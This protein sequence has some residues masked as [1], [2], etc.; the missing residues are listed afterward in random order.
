MQSVIGDSFKGKNGEVQFA[1]IDAQIVCLLF[2][3][4][5]CPPCRTFLTVLSDFY[6]SVNSPKKRLEIIHITSDKDEAGFNEHFEQAP[7][8]CIPY[9]DQRIDALKHKFKIAGVP[10]L[11]VLNKDG[12]LANGIA[13]SDVETDG[14]SCFDHWLSLVN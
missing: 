9:S 13:K 6:L 14:P 10:V 12:T 8:V 7:W 11:L 3:A 5:W 4:N 1:E 2:T